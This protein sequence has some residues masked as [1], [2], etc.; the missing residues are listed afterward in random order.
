MNNII[1][2]SDMSENDSSSTISEIE[3]EYST[4][5]DTDSSEHSSV[6]TGGARGFRKFGKRRGRGRSR[7]KNKRNDK[8]NDTNKRNDKKNDTKRKKRRNIRD[9]TNENNDNT[10]NTNKENITNDEDTTDD[11]TNRKKRDNTDDLS[12]TEELT[13]KEKKES[14]NSNSVVIH[15]HYN[16]GNCRCCKC[17]KDNQDG[18]TLKES[19]DIEN[20]I[21]TPIKQEEKQIKKE[22]IIPKK[23]KCNS[24]AKF[25]RLCNE[26][27]D[28]LMN[29]KKE[30]KP[31][32]NLFKQNIDNLPETFD[33]NLQ[34]LYNS[35]TNKKII[36][37]LDNFHLYSKQLTYFAD[38][39]NSFKNTGSE[40]IREK[41]IEK[42]NID[43]EILFKLIK[44]NNYKMSNKK[45]YDLYDYIL[46]LVW[47]KRTD[48]YSDKK[49]DHKN[50]I[51][52][53]QDYIK[54]WNEDKIE[55]DL[56]Y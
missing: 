14:D 19:S 24:I 33:E 18:G 7:S 3:K 27:S 11:D 47:T 2:L 36:T 28:D 34:N 32:I 38:I 48:V 41:I 39:T 54:K 51:K 44:E 21:K 55:Y 40:N 37:F 30:R 17:C 42:R 56:F 13:K 4:G 52:D 31:Y 50:I 45:L 16:D 29:I 1:N 46:S 8:K 22:K 20:N 12:E 49:E 25:L 9:N 15:N 53:L 35:K 23:K 5:D 43:N 6:M 10:S 26:P